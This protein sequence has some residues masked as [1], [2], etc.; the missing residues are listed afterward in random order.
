MHS[1]YNRTALCRLVYTTTI[2]DDGNTRLQSDYFKN[3][4]RQALG[5]VPRDSEPSFPQ[6]PFRKCAE[7]WFSG[8]RSA[9]AMMRGKANERASFLALKAKPFIKG[10]FEVGMIA[11]K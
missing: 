9:E 7:S 4:V 11:Q 8:S 5:L 10:F 3:A 6:C 2:Q 1:A